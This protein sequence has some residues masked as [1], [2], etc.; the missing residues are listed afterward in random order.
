MIIRGERLHIGK[1]KK[2]SFVL[3]HIQRYRFAAKWA[4]KRTVLDLGCGEGYGTKILKRAGAS[5]IIGVDINKEVIKQAKKN[6]S[7]KSVFFQEGDAQGLEFKDKS[8]DLVISLELIEHLQNYKK[9]LKE[10][11]RVLKTKGV[12]ILSTP[13]KDNYRGESSPFH[14]KEFSLEELRET[15]TGLFQKVEIF[16]QQITNPQIADS[17]RYFFNLYQRLTF[18]RSLTKK[19]FLLIPSEIKAFFYKNLFGQT[20]Q[21]MKSDF[22]IS[23]RKLSEAITFLVLCQK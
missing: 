7:S 17:E 21:A 9:Y 18:G 14:V 1:D 5:K 4:N 19:L 22:K 11:K 12:F 23:K 2:H 10:V 3:E 16:G 13:N 20:P 6:Y 8:F 15:L